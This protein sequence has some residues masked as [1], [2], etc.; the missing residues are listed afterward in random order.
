MRTIDW[1][2][3]PYTALEHL[4]ELHGK[5]FVAADKEEWDLY[6]EAYPDEARKISMPPFV[7]DMIGH[8][9]YFTSGEFGKEENQKY[10]KMFVEGLPVDYV[11]ALLAYIERYPMDTPLEGEVCN[12]N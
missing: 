12:F 1:L 3:D 5:R 9:R 4:K 8:F 10:F 11:E 2:D 6:V 7:V